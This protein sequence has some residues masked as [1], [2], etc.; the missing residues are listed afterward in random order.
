MVP[1]AIPTPMSVFCRLPIN[2]D[3]SLWVSKTTFYYRSQTQSKETGITYLFELPF[4]HKI[5][6]EIL[7]L[8]TLC[9][10]ILADFIC[11]SSASAN[12]YSSMSGK[13]IYTFRHQNH[14]FTLYSMEPN[15]LSSKDNDPPVICIWLFSLQKFPER[16]QFCTGICIYRM[17]QDLVGSCG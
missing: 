8:K 6:L 2:F 4:L 14:F 15:A 11:A 7:Y 1:E 13:M 5:L 17:I 12:K 9:D 3:F 16:G 10:R